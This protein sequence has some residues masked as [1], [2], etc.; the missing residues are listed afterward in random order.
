MM[1]FN[2]VENALN[3][4]QNANYNNI[5]KISHTLLSQSLIKN[6]NDFYSNM[7]RLLQSHLLSV[8]SFIWSLRGDLKFY[9]YYCSFYSG[10]NDKTHGC[11]Y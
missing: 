11:E 5:Y 2:F 4:C 8:A 7:Y 9:I 10:V 3:L 6:Q 1:F